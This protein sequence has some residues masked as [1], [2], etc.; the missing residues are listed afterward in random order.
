MSLRTTVAA[1]AA[2]LS[3]ALPVAAS[4][5]DL[6]V[7][8]VDLQRVLLEVDDGKAAKARL[9]KWLEE[10]QK[11]IDKEQTALRTEKETLDKQS[12]AMTPDVRAQKEADLQ[13]KVMV[14]AQ[15]WEKSRGEAATKERQE[16]EPIINKIDQ[17]VAS[18]A[19]R[20][21]LGM[22]LDK[23]DSGIVFAKAQYDISN[24]V[25]RAYNGSKTTK[26]TAAKDAPT[27]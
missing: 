7:A 17:V 11:E 8:Y 24:E 22:V 21:D 16:M 23:R 9:Q 20:D 12:S 2:V 6:K 25:I 13:R 18:I 1:M 10:K 14:L 19:Q 4:A 5:A 27:K 26:T 3:L 15:K